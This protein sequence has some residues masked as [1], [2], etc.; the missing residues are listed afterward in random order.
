MSHSKLASTPRPGG[1]RGG[2]ITPN[3]Q[4]Q[5]PGQTPRPLLGWPGPPGVPGRPSP[6]LVHP[7]PSNSTAM[8][9]PPVALTM[10]LY[11][12]S[13]IS[14]TFKQY[15]CGTGEARLSEGLHHLGAYPDVP[16]SSHA[17]LYPSAT[18]RSRCAGPHGPCAPSAAMGRDVSGRGWP[19][20]QTGLARE[21]QDR[22]LT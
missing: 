1:A 9:P 18:Q 10:Q 13:S 2:G 16:S 11:S 7:E 14:F 5:E 6:F 20:S 4:K 3:L 22:A 15:D 12:S 21:A 17:T 19:L 8:P